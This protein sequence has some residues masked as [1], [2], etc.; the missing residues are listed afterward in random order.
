MELGLG[1]EVRVRTPLLP[2][3]SSTRY[4][5]SFEP[6]FP[7]KGKVASPLIRV[8]LGFVR[9]EAYTISKAPFVKNNTKLLR[10]ITEVNI[11]FE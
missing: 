2:T 10:L 7:E 3:L 9:Y 1:W 11:C 4:G 6:S 5:C 8:D